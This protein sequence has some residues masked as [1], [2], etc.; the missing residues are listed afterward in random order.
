M[1]KH[2]T[3]FA[4]VLLL[5]ASLL[6]VLLLGGCRRNDPVDSTSGQTQLTSA[7]TAAT[8]TVQTGEET[9]ETTAAA[10][11]QTQ[12]G[13]GGD[14]SGTQQ[15]TKPSSGGSQQPTQPQTKPTEGDS[16]QQ[17]QPQTTGPQVDG[18]VEDWTA[19]TT[20][21]EETQPATEEATKPAAESTQA[22]GPEKE[23]TD[24]TYSQYLTLKPEEQE[25]FMN[26]FDSVDAYLAWYKAAYA[27][28]AE[29]REVITGSGN[30]N[31]GDYIGN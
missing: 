7:E 5:A 18:D 16:Q 28:Y 21:S 26:A 29:N 25:R 15:P 22:T 12:S 2:A 8:T 20:V 11:E 13:S 19:D 23:L 27:A 9:Q 17:T 6:T 31:I 10:T 30:I 1:K 3:V 14:H 4:V 24:L